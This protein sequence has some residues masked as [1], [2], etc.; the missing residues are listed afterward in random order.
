MFSPHSSLEPF[1]LFSLNARVLALPQTKEPTRPR[2]PASRWCEFPHSPRKGFARVRTV[3]LPCPM[4]CC[5]HAFILL[6]SFCRPL[7]F[8]SAANATTDRF[9]PSQR[10]LRMKDHAHR[11]A[12]DA[13]SSNLLQ[14]TNASLSCLQQPL[15]PSSIAY[16][17]N[18]R[19]HS[20]RALPQKH[21]AVPFVAV[22]TP[23]EDVQLE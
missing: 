19:Y 6:T 15:W 4:M 11:S 7:G 9:T 22:T 2:L 16:R 21:P 20:P 8:S 12:Y 1:H 17:V 3:L 23:T 18:E 14:G 5:P 13:C 10:P